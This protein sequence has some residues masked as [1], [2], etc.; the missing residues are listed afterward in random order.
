[1]TSRRRFWIGMVA[2]VVAAGGATYR[3]RRS[4][5]APPADRLQRSPDGSPVLVAPLAH[6]GAAD[7]ALAGGKGANLG[8]LVRAG[9]AVPPSFVVAAPCRGYLHHPAQN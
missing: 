1:M 4:R 3:L 5:P 7:I 9:F 6:F 8:E 2:A